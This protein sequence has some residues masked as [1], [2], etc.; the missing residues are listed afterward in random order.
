M[1]LINDFK[2]NDYKYKLNLERIR[3]LA[4]YRM[5]LNILDK[6]KNKLK[7]YK[8]QTTKYGLIWLRIVKTEYIIILIHVHRYPLA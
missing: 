7:L 6:V 1:C 5:K 4:Q 8:I 2:K 3:I